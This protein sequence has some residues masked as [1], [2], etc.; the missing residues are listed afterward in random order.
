[1]V[2]KFISSL[3][4]NTRTFVIVNNKYNY[5]ELRYTFQGSE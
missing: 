3:Y 4:A 5:E 1:M 2:V